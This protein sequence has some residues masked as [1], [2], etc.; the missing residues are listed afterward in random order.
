MESRPLCTLCCS[1]FSWFVVQ[2]VAKALTEDAGSPYILAVDNSKSTLADI[3]TAIAANLGTGRTH[4]L[5][6][7]E[8]DALL[9]KQDYVADLNVSSALA[10]C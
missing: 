10:V 8:A 9:L 6:P 5:P 4:V 1:R 7:T 3:T 2:I